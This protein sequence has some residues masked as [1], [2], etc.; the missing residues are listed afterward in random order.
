MEARFRA[1]Y[2]GE[3][4]VI[5]SVWAA[6][7]KTHQREW[8]ANPIEN[9]HISGRAICIGSRDADLS[10]QFNHRILQRHRGGLLGTLKLQTYGVGTIAEDMRLDFTVEIDPAQITQLVES[11]YYEDNVVYT[12][13]R[14]CIANPG[15]FY[16][17]PQAPRLLLPAL[18]VYL[19]AFDGHQEIFLL[20]YSSQMVYEN[21]N[22]FSDVAEVFQAYSGVKFWLVGEPSI[23]P[24]LWLEYTN[25]KTMPYRDF[26][27]YADI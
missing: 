19:A 25:V 11:K 9:Q 8:I 13:A 20:G 2:P 3:F 12:T 16:L 27:G 7:K 24:D 6:G 1:D 5:N 22:W 18:P 17:I 10:G 23:M 15:D 4:V 26:I 21:P 14:N